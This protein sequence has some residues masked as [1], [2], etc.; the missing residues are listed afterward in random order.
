MKKPDR[1][2]F[3]IATIGLVVGAVCAA[4]SPPGAV[5][6]RTEIEK[7]GMRMSFPLLDKKLAGES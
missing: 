2:K 5:P 1:K 7:Q 3:V 4:A 6:K